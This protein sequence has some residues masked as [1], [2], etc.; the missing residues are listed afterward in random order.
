M[1]KQLKVPGDFESFIMLQQP[2]KFFSVDS[3][4]C[5]FVI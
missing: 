3:A 2:L 5:F 4:A 1:Y